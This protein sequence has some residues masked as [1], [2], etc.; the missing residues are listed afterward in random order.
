KEHVNDD[1]FYL[2]EDLDMES[3]FFRVFEELAPLSP[4]LSESQK[5]LLRLAQ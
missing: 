3:P 4:Y 5:E 1:L 2:V